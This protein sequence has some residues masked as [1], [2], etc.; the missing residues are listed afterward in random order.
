[1]VSGRV[2]ALGREWRGGGDGGM[3]PFPIFDTIP[4]E[5]PDDAASSAIV[6][7]R[8]LRSRRTSAPIPASRL[9]GGSSLGANE[10][11]LSSPSTSRM[12][13]RLPTVRKLVVDGRRMRAP[14]LASRMALGRSPGRPEIK[15]APAASFPLRKL[16]CL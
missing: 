10:P 3:A 8:D 4:A 16:M 14:W 2:G 13:S 7:S 5:V 9:R 12:A 1:G 11:V 15:I 6:K